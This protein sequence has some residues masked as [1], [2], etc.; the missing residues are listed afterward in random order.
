MRN[1]ELWNYGI[2]ELLNYRII[3]LWK[4]EIILIV[5]HKLCKLKSFFEIF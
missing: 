1:Q 4:F 2:I 3:E 5:I